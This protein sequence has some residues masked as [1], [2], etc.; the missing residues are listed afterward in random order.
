MFYRLLST[1][2]AGAAE[3]AVDSEG[4]S[5]AEIYAAASS[6]SKCFQFHGSNS[7]MRLAG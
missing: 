5:G 2:T 3:K 6:G 4:W 7:A 1:H